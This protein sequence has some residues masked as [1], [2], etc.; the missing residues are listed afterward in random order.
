[1]PH[2]PDHQRADQDPEGRAARCRRAASLPNNSLPPAGVFDGALRG[3][4]FAYDAAENLLTRTSRESGIAETTSLPLDGSGRN[5]PGSVDGVALTWD[6]NGNLVGKGDLEF[7]Y[8]FRNRLTRVSRGSEEVARY[9]YDAF[10]RKIET[11]AG[12]EAR[13][14]VWSGWQAIETRGAAGF[15]TRRIYGVGLDEIVR[16]EVDI[17][18][19]GTAETAHLPVYDSTGSLVAILDEAGK[20]IERYDYSPYG[21]RTIRADLTVPEVEQ[22][23]VVD[24]MLWLE[25]SERVSAEHLETLVASGAL[26]LENLTTTTT[27]P[28]VSLEV[29]VQQGRQAGRRIVLALGQSPATGNELRLTLPAGA[30]ADDFLNQNPSAVEAT[31]TWSGADEVVLD[32]RAPAISQVRIRSGRVEIEL[33]EEVVAAST[34]STVTIDGEPTTWELTEDRYTLRS[35]EDLATGGHTVSLAP[36]IED[37][38]GRS[39]PEQLDVSFAP[40]LSAHAGYRRADPTVIP[41]TSAANPYGFHGH[42]V[43][44]AT[45]LVYMRNRWYDPQMGR[46]VTADPLGY[47]DGPSAYGFGLNDP[48]NHGDPLGLAVYAFDGTWNDRSTMKNPTNVAKLAELYSG[49]LSFYQPGVGVYDYP[50]MGGAF[51][52]G[53]KSRLRRMWLDLARAFQAGDRE[54]IVLGFSRGA[55]LARTFVNW[56]DRYGVPDLSSAERIVSHRTRDGDPVYRTVYRRWHKGVKVRFLGLFDT[57]GSFGIPGNSADLGYDLGIPGNVEIVRHAIA[58]DEFR[59]GFPLTSAIDPSCPNDSRIVEKSFA[60]AHSDVG[61]GYDDQDLLAHEPLM[62]MWT[63]LTKAGLSFR[64]IEGSDTDTVIRGQEHLYSHD[65]MSIPENPTSPI[66][67]LETF[68]IP[69]RIAMDGAVIRNVYPSKNSCVQ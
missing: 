42:E 19:D 48:A 62:W 15:S 54:I 27:V 28:I 53:G 37:L 61:G 21:E 39:Q 59:K 2:P 14:T 29:P 31:W 58:Q 67:W 51:G 65:P 13:E 33:T 69:R 25:A 60:G 3:R 38:A 52:F 64:P 30:L 6:A 63:E 18:G 55:A 7:H 16:Q 41:T 34:A 10:N 22:V 11:V 23:R 56:I 43:D 47:V 46:F 68:Q 12:G 45:G 24:G 4:A 44:P 20:P 50:F 9:R 57:V 66:A 1:L 32:T 36:G 5:R 26:R 8:D 35:L 49:A 17:D 40:G